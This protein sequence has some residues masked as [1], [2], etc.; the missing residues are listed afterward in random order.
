LHIAYCILYKVDCGILKKETAFVFLYN[1]LMQKVLD[2]VTQS[3]DRNRLEINSEG[4]SNTDADTCRRHY[5]KA[6]RHTDTL[7]SFLRKQS[8]QLQNRLVHIRI[9]PIQTKVAFYEHRTTGALV[10]KTVDFT[11]CFQTLG[12][13]GQIRLPPYA[14]NVSRIHALMFHLKHAD[15][16]GVF[17]ILDLWSKGGTVVAGTTHASLPGNRRVL[18]VPDHEPVML[19]LGGLLDAPFR[20]FLN[21]KECLICQ[22]ALR[23]EL[24]EMCQHL[25]ACRAC[26]EHWVEQSDS[27]TCPIC[28]KE[29]SLQRTRNADFEKG[30]FNTCNIATHL[31]EYENEYEHKM[32]R[33]HTLIVKPT[34]GATED[35][36]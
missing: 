36:S 25:V 6:I 10:N 15:G 35:D 9:S 20:I 8:A 34:A 3:F 12:R 13:F 23:T 17:V 16:R 29:V 11:S 22:S 4:V 19:Q 14:A 27:P 5:L 7:Q 18:I 2:I 33:L 24:F 32:N 21:A 28:R 1:T 30:E 31:S 26:L